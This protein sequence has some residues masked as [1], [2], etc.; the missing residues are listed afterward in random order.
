MYLLIYVNPRLA[1]LNDSPGG[2]IQHEITP[3]LSRQLADLGLSEVASYWVVATAKL[4]HDYGHR[5]ACASATDDGVLDALCTLHHQIDRARAWA[6]RALVERP[7]PRAPHYVA[8]LWERKPAR[9]YRELL[10]RDVEAAIGYAP[11]EVLS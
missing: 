6:Q 8:D 11:V 2:K 5:L 4:P 1:L 3:A 10:G 9:L 7:R